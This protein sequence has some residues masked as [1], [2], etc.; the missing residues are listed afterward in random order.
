M[1]SLAGMRKAAIL[2]GRRIP[3]WFP[4]GL[5]ALDQPGVWGDGD[6]NSVMSQD[7]VVFTPVTDFGQQIGLLLDKRLWQG[8]TLAQEIAARTELRGNGAIGLVGTAGAATYDTNTGAAAVERGSSA[9]NQS[10]VQW[11]SLNSLELYRVDIENTGSPSIVVRS[12]GASASVSLTVAAG[13]RV[14]GFVLPGSGAI[15]IG[16]GANNSTA[17]FILHSA[18]RIPGNHLWQE[19]AASRPVWQEDANGA[20]GF[21]FDGS[22]DFFVSRAPIDFSASDKVLV[23][24]G[25]RKLSDVT[26]GPIA[27]IGNFTND[28]HFLITCPQN[29]SNS[30]ANFSVRNPSTTA[31][32]NNF[33]A[34]AS[35]VLTGLAD[36]GAGSVLLRQNGAQVGSN[37]GLSA[38]NFA[39]ATLALGFYVSTYFN[40][41]VHQLVVRG[42]ALPD[43]AELAQLENFI[44]QKSKVAA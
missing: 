8:R 36:R 38:G 18:R 2:G 17:S 43:A 35:A 39:N 27:Q 14:T 44:A 11:T 23:S 13:Q 32:G 16:S 6:D 26:V 12:G 29:G 31:L 15:T 41:F 4:S 42:G 25:V 10:F 24:A 37:S 22:N 3:T 19:T 28:G 40:G 7:P 20:R 33:A 21:R 34:P 30:R 5:F 1:V 9:G